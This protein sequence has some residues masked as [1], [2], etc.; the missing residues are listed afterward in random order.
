MNSL[1][2]L[3]FIASRPWER[4]LFTTY[5][6]SLTFFETYLLPQL[7]KAGC[8]QILIL[9]DVDGYRGSL[10]ELKSRHIGQEYS[11]IPVSCK[12]GIFHP[13][14]TYLWGPEGD[15][16]M[17]GSGNLT[18]G[19]HGRNVEVLEVLEPSKDSDSFV[20]FSNFLNDL[21]SAENIDFPNK[22]DL[23]VFKNRSLHVA[24]NQQ[25]SKKTRL[26]HTL[27]ESITNQLQ[28]QASK[29][30][31]W[32]ELLVL[33]PFHNPEAKPIYE[34]AY[35]LSVKQLSIGVPP[36]SDETSSF[37]FIEAGKRDIEYKIVSPKVEQ[38]K[39]PL[40]AKWI[41]F[42]GKEN[43]ALTGSVNA[44]IQSLASTRNVEVGILRVLEKPSYDLWKSANRP[45]YKPN[46]I[47]NKSEAS[48]NPLLYAEMNGSGHI[49]GRFV[50]SN[51]FIGY[52]DAYLNRADEL[53][54]KAVVEV[55]ADGKFEWPI[56][57]FSEFQDSSSLQIN[58]IR[59]NI[60]ARGWVSVQSLL[61]LPTR[62]RGAINALSRM[63]NRSESLDD[64][65]ALLDFISV[66][67]GRVAA[68]SSCISPS[69]NSNHKEKSEDF[70]FPIS[71]L[72]NI[73]NPSET[74]LL[75]AIANSSA[76]E[77]KS[78][79]VLQTIT[80][81]LL[82]RKHNIQA[83][84]TPHTHSL[85]IRKQ[86]E[87]PEDAKA[88]QQ[89]KIAIDEFNDEV[90]K[91]IE[92]AS[93][94]EAKL[95]QLMF[96]WLSVNIDMYLRR[97]NDID[98]AFVIIEKWLRILARTTFYQDAHNLLDEPFTGVAAAL[99]LRMKSTESSGHVY[100]QYF[101]N[102][103]RLHQLMESYYAGEV[104]I[105]DVL[106]KAR[107]WLSHDTAQLLINEGIEGA[108]YALKNCLSEPTI[109]GILSKLF[110]SHNLGDQDFEIPTGVFSAEEEK[111]LI[112]VLRSPVEKRSYRNVNHHTVTGCPKCFINLDKD[113][114]IRLSSRR[115]AECINCKILLVS[116]EP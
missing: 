53:I 2:Q 55:N 13:K 41:E 81:L 33:S 96:I 113:T 30:N 91:L 85:V 90:N 75:R 106:N 111:Q 60:T 108:I 94:S 43:W 61:K 68:V 29:I 64:I 115:I 24:Q 38:S 102:K 95:A 5:A 72:A 40:H 83:N 49:Q 28:E 23:A 93:N 31:G 37:P 57:S 20:D 34:L 19:G 22:T 21:E 9:A 65:N 56:T 42:R 76:D 100:Q 89:T 46:L 4:A 109:R 54:A 14:V 63:L 17:V 82:G 116:L 67:A 45:D 12:S 15:L 58:L 88:L 70:N 16:L 78:W 99:A 26:L 98:G 47:E 32:N 103:A 66:H 39:R 87:N 110:A 71:D 92:N 10:M 104:N 114:K 51:Q 44:T 80:R 36:N 112:Q 1:S 59:E 6:L 52:W 11:L 97:L 77:N 79:H 8:E 73:D 84:K 50:G 107:A 35:A 69:N 62:T 18:F 101:L 7:R 3:D 105:D 48:S 27:H 74:H 25:S 86:I